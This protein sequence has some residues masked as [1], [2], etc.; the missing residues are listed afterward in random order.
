MVLSS[1][2][3]NR[4]PSAAE[5]MTRIAKMD[6]LGADLCK[7]AV[8][9]QCAEDVLTLLGVSVQA[10]AIFR[11]PLITMSMGRLGAVSRLCGS[12]SGSAVTFGTLG[13]ASAPGQLPAG[14]MEEIL[15]LL[16]NE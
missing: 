14:Q 3:F 2:D 11:A 15:P 8:M 4:T 12:L 16:G 10:S 9:P 5:M 1:H 6:G 7:I 13:D